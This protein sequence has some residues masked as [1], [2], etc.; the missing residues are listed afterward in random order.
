MLN[1]RPTFIQSPNDHANLLISQRVHIADDLCGHLSGLSSSVL[2]RPLHHRHDEGQGRGVDKVHK[3]GLQQGLQA[4]GRL[5]GWVLE[6]IQ[7]HWHNGCNKQQHI[8]YIVCLLL[9]SNLD[10]IIRSWRASSSTSTM[11]AIYTELFLNLIHIY[12]CKGG[13]CCQG[14]A[15]SL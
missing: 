15:R 11:A 4:G 6:G 7:Q 14:R 1:K 13:C 5:P 2:E 10:K 3:L 8:L 12:F 9:F